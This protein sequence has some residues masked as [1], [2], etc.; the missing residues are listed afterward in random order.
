LR[1]GLIVYRAAVEAAMDIKTVLIC[2]FLAGFVAC[3]IAY[4]LWLKKGEAQDSEESKT[5]K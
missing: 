2:V 4:A 5:A 3:A 1:G